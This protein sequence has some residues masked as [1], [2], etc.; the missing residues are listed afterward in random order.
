MWYAEARLVRRVEVAVGSEL[1]RRFVTGARTNQGRVCVETLPA[2]RFPVPTLYATNPVTSELRAGG[3]ITLGSD[4]PVESIDPLRG[5][6]AAMT[7]LDENG[8]SPMGAGGWY[9]PSKRRYCRILTREW[10]FLLFLRRYPDQKLTREEALR[11]MTIDGERASFL[12]YC[13][14]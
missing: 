2:V 4:F 10:G 13:D 14:V 3:R 6:Y 8:N 5:F 11:G 7:R 9:V 12:M 1:R